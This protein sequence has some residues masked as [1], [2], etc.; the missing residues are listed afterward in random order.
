MSRG[1]SLKAALTLWEAAHDGQKASEAAKV[2]LHIEC[3]DIHGA[4]ACCPEVRSYHCLIET[5]LILQIE[6]CGVCPPIE[7]LDA[8][9]A[10]LKLCK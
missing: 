10:G 8:N 6:L 3:F 4:I 1:T 7:K 9:L 5:H 2:G